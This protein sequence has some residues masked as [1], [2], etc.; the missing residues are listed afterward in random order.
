MGCHGYLPAPHFHIER[1]LP[2]RSTLARGRADWSARSALL[3]QEVR[4][5][6]CRMCEGMK[7]V[8]EA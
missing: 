4:W 3:A 7:R 5:K 6:C 2:L 1:I 8:L